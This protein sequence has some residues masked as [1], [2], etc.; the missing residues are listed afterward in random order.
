M[1]YTYNGILF[2]EEILQFVTIGMN[3]RNI[4]FSE[5]SKSQKDKYGMIVLSQISK[6]VK[7]KE[8]K[9]GMNVARGYREGK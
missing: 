5:I 1:V 4:M 2:S 9:C 6:T 3:F 8:P 7:F